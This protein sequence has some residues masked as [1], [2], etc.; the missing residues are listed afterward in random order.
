MDR[1]PKPRRRTVLAGVGTVLGAGCL[2]ADRTPAAT[3]IDW[4]MYGRDPGRTRFVPDAD[5]PRDGVEIVW[6]HS[7]GASGWRPPV[8]ANGTVYCQYANGLFVVDAKTGDG[9]ASNT[10][11]GFG[12]GVGPMAF[13]STTVYRDGVLLVPYGDV[14]AGYAADPDGWP[15]SVSG[16]GEGRARWWIDDEGVSTS[17]PGGIGSGTARRATPVVTDEGIVSLHPQGT[18]SAVAADDGGENWRYGLADANPDDEYS[19]VPVGHV[20][21]A[22]TGTVVVKGRVLGRPV[23]VGLDL[24]DGT[25]KW[26]VDEE[27]TTEW[28]VETQDSLSAADGAV[29]TVGWT[30]SNRTLR[31]RELDAA[32]G[33][34][35]WSR[36]LERSSH[37]GLAVDE[38][39]VYHVGT[40][41][42]DEGSD[43]IGIAVLNREDGSVRWTETVDDTAGSALTAGG[44]PPTVAGDLL[45][46]P[47]GEGLHALATADGERLWTFTET[48]GTSGGSETERA[49]LTPAVVA[50]NRIVIGTTLMLYGLG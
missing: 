35:G 19:I 14:I 25:R 4:R 47:G 37:V 7:V 50:G 21:D 5:L 45:L 16:L 2:G 33:E 28:Q 17:P 13:A 31:I 44:A 27:R 48:V 30:N 15:E 32:T 9:D 24:A 8:V 3:E 20:V 46:V 42:A 36:T 41:E 23:L 22:A 6:S 11:G 49:A 18:V 29:Y 12:R 34:R 1:V 26:T 10:Y 39:S 40:I 43:P 38:T